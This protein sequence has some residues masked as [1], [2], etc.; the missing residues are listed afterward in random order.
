[1]HELIEGCLGR[2]LRVVVLDEA[3]PF[4]PFDEVFMD[5][6]AELFYQHT[7]PQVMDS[8]AFQHAFGLGPL[9]LEQTVR[10]TLAWYRT[11]GAQQ[12]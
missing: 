9:T 3:R 10:D 6:Y 11:W 12:G 1:M 5:S 7:E 8:T 2:S 4:G